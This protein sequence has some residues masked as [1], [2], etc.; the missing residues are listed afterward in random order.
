KWENIYISGVN[1]KLLD[2]KAMENGISEYALMSNAAGM[3][4]N[5]LISSNVSAKSIAIVCGI[6]NNGGDGFALANLLWDQGYN[7]RV[8][9]YDSPRG[10]NSKRFFCDFIE[11]KGFVLKFSENR[12]LAANIITDSTIVID[13]LFGFSFGGQLTGDCLTLAELI[14]SG[15]GYVISVD[16]PSGVYADGG[17]AFGCICA[18]LTCTFT[19]NKASTCSYPSLEYCGTVA[20]CDI[21]VPVSAMNG[22]KP[23][24][25][26]ITDEI[27]SCLS[28]RTPNSNKGTY[29]TLLALCGSINMTGSAYLAAIGALRSG[30]GLL[31]MTSDR[32]T[33]AV[34]KNR[35]SEPVFV[36]FIRDILCEEK[37]TALLVGCGIGR[38]YDNLLDEILTHQ[39][40]I[41]IID[42]DGINYIASHINVLTE[43][44]GD[45][46]LTPHPGEM[47]RLI[48]QS[49]DY[50]N[51]NRI[52][53]AKAFAMEFGCVLVLKGN[54][55]II[56]SPNGSVFISPS[57]NTSL[58]KG[59]SGDVLAGVISSL[60][61]QG[62]SPTKAACLGAYV[63][64]L[65][66][67]NL[68]K[69]YGIRGLLP[70][71]LPQE[72]GRI[73]G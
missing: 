47:A 38:N 60:A 55:T 37:Y 33:L 3:I 71:D 42:A 8:I 12:E 46:I 51:S 16:L 29:G 27:F 36:P 40:Q 45:V 15:D 21:G 2:N 24:G 23:D 72:I 59:G 58:S 30:V 7:P 56:A 57:G 1:A 20:L 25:F 32:E 73:L 26:I 68:S 62:I 48:G 43:M 18:D 22:I 34:L 53:C 63:H 9:Y 70:H 17:F 50:V 13:A 5:A 49:V 69:K 19:V 66:A 52:E 39:K 14:N 44:Q 31:K 35:L 11:K 64:G 61:A 41:T 6:G 10:E 4:Y 65:A 54:H 28:A 67:E